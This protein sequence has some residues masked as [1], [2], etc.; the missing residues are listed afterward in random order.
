MISF[1]LAP[2]F[3]ENAKITWL[4]NVLVLLTAE[5]IAEWEE[6]ICNETN[7]ITCDVFQGKDKNTFI[8]VVAK[9]GLRQIKLRLLSFITLDSDRLPQHQI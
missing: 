3:F 1:D 6:N 4:S 7:E 2:A 9:N 5:N 8:L